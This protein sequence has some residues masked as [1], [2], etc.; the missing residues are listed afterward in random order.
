MLYK[1]HAN[2][3]S[4]QQNLGTIKSSNLCCEIMEYTSADEVAVCN[5]ASVCLPMFV[6]T[7]GTFNYEKLHEVTRNVTKNLNRVIDVNYYPIPEAKN[8]N[9]RHRPIGIGI[10]GLADTLIKMK[11]AYEDD[12]A[13]SIN[14]KIFETMYH[15]AMSESIELAKKEGHYESFKGSPLS[16]GKFQFDLWNEK[17]AT[18]RYDWEGLR[19]EVMK[20]GARNSLLMA[21]MPT[22]ST[23][24]I[25]GNNESFE[26]YTTNIYTRRVLAGEFVCVNPHLVKDLIKLNMWTPETRNKLVADQGSVQNMKDLPQEFKKIYKTIWEIS[27]KQL[28]KLAR[29]RAP[30][31]CQSQSLNIYF[32]EPTQNKLSASHMYAW[33]LGL[34][35]G[36]YYLRSRPARDAIQFTLDVDAL[37][38][39][40]DA[41]YNTKNLSKAEMDAKKKEQRVLRK[42]PAPEPI[43]DSKVVGSASKD[44]NKKR[45]ITETKETTQTKEAPKAEA[46]KEAKPWEG[47]EEKEQDYRWDICENC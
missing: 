41:N 21:P 33:Q 23:A 42:R 3:K 14:S 17:P 34:K 19:Q 35:T 30:Y 4:N 6:N 26:P 1:D 12:V 2:G 22:A 43:A 7:D 9:M 31:I 37:D 18:D 29:A 40:E 44:L 10:Q 25:M 11:V 28:I 36:Q 27:Q 16:E 8:S 32:A 45:K 15:A 5:L 47:K 38:V 24:Q 46:G 20:H 39:K 13:E